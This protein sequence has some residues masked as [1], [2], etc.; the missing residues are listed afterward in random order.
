MA[1]TARI[2]AEFPTALDTVRAAV[3][4]IQ[5]DAGAAQALSGLVGKGVGQV[6]AQFNGLRGEDA[7]TPIGV[8]F[9]AQATPITHYAVETGS[10]S[11]DAV[12]LD[13]GPLLE[14]RVEA[15]PALAAHARLDART[16][17]NLLRRARAAKLAGL[18]AALHTAAF[19]R[20]RLLP[21]DPASDAHSVQ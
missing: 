13:G 10:T 19:A 8:D 17:L 2:A 21:E 4:A 1:P 12:T 11:A 7:G 16:R 5:A 6:D 14:V 20:D 3:A 15:E 18:V 9:D